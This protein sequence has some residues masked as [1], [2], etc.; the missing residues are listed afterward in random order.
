MSFSKHPKIVKVANICDLCHFATS[1]NFYF[2]DFMNDWLIPTPP[3]PF[4]II[5][6]FWRSKAF[7]S[8]K[9]QQIKSSSLIFS[10][11]IHPFFGENHTK[12]TPICFIHKIPLNLLNIKC[13][14]HSK[15]NNFFLSEWTNK[16][17]DLDS[18]KKQW[19]DCT[20]CSCTVFCC[21]V[22]L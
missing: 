20:I 10:P 5:G 16:N 17:R 22:N 19:L 6:L 21:N 14:F 11:K 7:F 18:L 13:P 1:S 3:F 8:H 4:Y 15:N 12:I 9:K 2:K